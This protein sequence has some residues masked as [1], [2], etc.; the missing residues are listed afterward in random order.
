MKVRL[1]DDVRGSWKLLS[2]WVAGIWSVIGG[3]CIY[4]P[5]LLLQVWNAIPADLR[6]DLPSWARG[7][8]AGLFAFGTW[9]AARVV[10]QPVRKPRDE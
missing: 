4:D 1:I 10:K 5:S 3:Y 8:I 7:L 6:A 2:T 9:Y